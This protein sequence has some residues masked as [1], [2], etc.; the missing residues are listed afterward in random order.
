LFVWG[1]SDFLNRYHERKREEE[2]FA[3]KKVID[4]S[5]KVIGD[6]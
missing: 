2:K 4:L 6:K 1:G 5:G 3:S